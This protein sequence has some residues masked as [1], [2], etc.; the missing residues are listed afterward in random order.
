MTTTTKHQ[1][2]KESF[3][4]ASRG[5]P[6]WPAAISIAASWVWAPALF[7][8]AEQA[9]TNGW[10]GL[11]WFTIPNILVLIVFAWF[12][13]RMRGRLPDGFTLSGYMKAR[14]SPRVQRVYIGQL[15]ALAICS[16]AVQM[17]AGGSV[18][19]FITGWDYWII[20]VLMAAAAL[21]YSAISG[22][23]ASIAADFFHIAMTILVVISFAPAVIN[24]VGLDAVARGMS[25]AHVDPWALALSFG[26]PTAIGL[27]SG[28]F[29]D[30]SFWQRSFAIQV[31]HVRRAFTLSAFFF[32]IV[33]LS[34]AVLGF[35][36]KGVGL[37]PESA[38]LVNVQAVYDLLP[39]WAIIPFTIMVIGALVSTMDNNLVSSSTLMGHDLTRTGN[40]IARGRVA[41]LAAAV[42]GTAVAN[43]PV[44][45][46]TIL[47]LIYGTLRASTLAPTVLTF[48][49]DKRPP[50]ER[51]VF[52]SIVGALT[53]G[54][55]LFLYGSF[56]DGAEVF[57][58]LGS[59]TTITVATITVLATR[60][61]AKETDPA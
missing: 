7:T 3:F 9:F 50:S 18:I 25:S 51:G 13:E 15:S 43:I 60:E 29:G 31:Q 2:T 4:A 44:I 27:M 48:I 34:M 41:M 8:S 24:N 30:Q 38:Q 35:A 58:T 39:P 11:A 1:Q 32:A 23:R 49:L 10:M 26:I 52:W 12:A 45:T 28:P 55:P 46:V 42:V 59:I 37:T 47:F 20:T 40:P 56:V 19:A 53:L 61:P 21:S 33:P 36:A 6:L 5:V 54:M 57:K 16:F 17:V 14:Y 22:L